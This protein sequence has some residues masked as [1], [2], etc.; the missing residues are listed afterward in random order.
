MRRISTFAASALLGLAVLATSSPASAFDLTA[1]RRTVHKSWPCGS[2]DA[3][4][5]AMCK[6]KLAA[7]GPGHVY[8][9]TWETD[10]NGVSQGT[11]HVDPK[12]P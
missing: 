8:G 12:F 2:D 11:C 7:A 3:G 4:C 6:D 10:A 5:H 9:I 1:P